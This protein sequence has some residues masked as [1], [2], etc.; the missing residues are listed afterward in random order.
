MK[1][2]KLTDQLKK[3]N[4]ASVETK[5]RL[6]PGRTQD[7]VRSRRKTEET[8]R[9]SG[10]EKTLK[11]R[12]G[13]PRGYTPSCPS[14]LY[15]QCRPRISYINKLVYLTSRSKDRATCS[16]FSLPFTSDFTERTKPSPVLSG[17]LQSISIKF[18]HEIKLIDQ[19][20]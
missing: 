3:D 19:V 9:V 5:H 20:D 10:I 1:S 18:L 2:A 4:G 11:E 17:S 6:F 16:K 15:L 7:R 8:G 12:R 14:C 13:I